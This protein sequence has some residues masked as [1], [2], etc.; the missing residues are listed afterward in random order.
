M[1][2]A[3]GRW[4]FIL[5]GITVLIFLL[6]LAYDPLTDQ[7]ALVSAE[8]ATHPWMLITHMF[9]HGGFEHLLYNM[10][11]LVLFGSILERVI[12]SRRFLVLYF[13]A[14][15]FAGL[16][17]M[18]MYPASLGASGAIFGI[19]GALTVLRPRLTVW[20]GGIPMPM[21]LASVVW[22]SI[23]MIGLLFPGQT[24]N[25]AHLVG[26]AFGIMVAWLF[27]KKRFGEPLFFNRKKTLPLSDGEAREWEDR[28]L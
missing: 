17:A 18:F 26:L 15:F 5:T 10:F 16:G 12:G 24:A 2:P 27:W 25:M 4:A 3:E 8:V 20:V 11:A 19:L 9:A 14:G 22:G 1:L 21:I 28:W 7:L 13:V 23:D 6:Q